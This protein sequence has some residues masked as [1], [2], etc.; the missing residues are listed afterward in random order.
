MFKMMKAIKIGL[1]I[2]DCVANK[3]Y[4]IACLSFN[5]LKSEYAEKVITGKFSADNYKSLF[6]DRDVD[7]YIGLLEK[8]A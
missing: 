1:E 8:K 7:Y 6:V 5:T 3:P 2:N 4:A